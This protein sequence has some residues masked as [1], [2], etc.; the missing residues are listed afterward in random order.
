MEAQTYWVHGWERDDRRAWMPGRIRAGLDNPSKNCV[1][2]D[3]WSGKG[4]TVPPLDSA[5]RARDTDPDIVTLCGVSGRKSF[6][7]AAPSSS[8]G[9]NQYTIRDNLTLVLTVQHFA[10]Y[11]LGRVS[12]ARR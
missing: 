7:V 2:L 5:A 9:Q 1:S 8:Y 4:A 11:R 12:N 3:P 10:L 6:R